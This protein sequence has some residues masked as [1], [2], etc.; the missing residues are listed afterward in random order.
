[1]QQLHL[2][3]KITFSAPSGPSNSIRQNL[4]INSSNNQKKMFLQRRRSFQP[5]LPAHS[6]VPP[7]RKFYTNFRVDGSSRNIL[8]FPAN[9][10]ERRASFACS[11]INVHLLHLSS[12]IVVTVVISLIAGE[13][14][15]CSI[16]SGDRSNISASTSEDDEREKDFAGIRK[17]VP[18]E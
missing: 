13:G 17:L 8:L 3:Q 16:P 4:P 5:P 6:L 10:G 14:G 11:R 2:L 9:P 15:G 18:G 7:H 1:M 12:A